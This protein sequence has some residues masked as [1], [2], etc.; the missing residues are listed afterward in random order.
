[1]EDLD[2][3]TDH[4]RHNSHMFAV[5][6]GKQINPDLT[7]QL[8]RAAIKSLDARG[9]VST[10][11]STAWKINIRARLQEG[12]K[13]HGLIKSLIVPAK[14]ETTSGEKAGLYMNLFDAHPPFQI[15]GNFGYTAG[16]TEM[17]LQSQNNIIH[18]LPAL[19]DDWKQGS[20]SGIKARGNIEV[21]IDWQNRKLVQ[22]SLKPQH[23]DVYQIQYKNVLK[24]VKMK[25][26]KLYQLD[27]LFFN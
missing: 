22:C 3:S 2:D 8:A 18:L 4:H 15:D 17:L 12:N 7:P 20:I 13:A 16:I 27:T 10:G 19:P 21:Q 14:A 26:G 23:T 5:H 1:M 24:K 6:P 25:A 11:W 9:N